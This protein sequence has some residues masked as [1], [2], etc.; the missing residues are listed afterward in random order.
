MTATTKGVFVRHAT[1]HR[2][3]F[4]RDKRPSSTS[5][6]GE[7]TPFWLSRQWYSI[8]Y[9]KRGAFPHSSTS[10]TLRWPS[11]LDEFG[12]PIFAAQ[13]RS[14]LRGDP[15]SCGAIPGLDGEG[16]LTAPAAVRDSSHGPRMRPNIQCPLWVKA[17]LT[18]P[19]SDFR[20]TPESGLK[21]DIA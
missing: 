14:F 9:Q 10:P 18:A 15:R 3:V 5:V 12:H 19:K 2:C 1:R 21:T 13:K 8:H 6:G 4:L 17:A 7:G 11:V 16:S 20:Y